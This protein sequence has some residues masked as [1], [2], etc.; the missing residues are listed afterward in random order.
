MSSDILPH[1]RF[2]FLGLD[3]SPRSKFQLISAKSP[4]NSLRKCAYFD[5]FWC[6]YKSG[7][8]I[9]SKQYTF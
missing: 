6:R 1:S 5:V 4:R 7:A 8:I 9:D 3:F 2:R